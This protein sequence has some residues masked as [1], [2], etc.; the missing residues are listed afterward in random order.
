MKY[1]IMIMFSMASSLGFARDAS[2]YPR[3]NAALSG[4]YVGNY[5]GS[6]DGIFKL[7]VQLR[8][9][10]TYS[11]EEKSILKDAIQF[12]IERA[13]KKEVLDCAFSRSTKDLPNSRSQFEIQLASALSPFEVEGLRMN[14]FQFIARF[15]NDPGAVG[16]GYVNLFYDTSLPQPGF[17]IKNHFH[18]ALNSDFIG[19]DS[20][21]PFATDTEYWAGIIGHEFLHNLGYDHPSGYKGSFI[22]E[23]G[24][25][26]TNNGASLAEPEGIV[27]DKS[28]HK[29]Y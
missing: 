15:W 25:C 26:L 20:L 11:D 13:L 12:Y 9:D 17:Q 8:V 7:G 10:P 16:Y 28:V 29:E 23:Y 27:R 22:Q 3:D 6:Y 21:Y 18:I 4:E 5:Q 14:A 1:L 19:Q 2:R 24:L